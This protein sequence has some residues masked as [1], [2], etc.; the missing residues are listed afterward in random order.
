MNGLEDTFDKSF[1][2]FGWLISWELFVNFVVSA[3]DSGSIESIHQGHF[4]NYR[5]GKF[6]GSGKGFSRFSLN[7][8]AKAKLN[9]PISIGVIYGSCE[10]K[11]GFWIN[12]SRLLAESWC[13]VIP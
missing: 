11:S 8:V 10:E 2:G 6:L 1:L 9:W 7:H 12:E 5:T 4:K 3:I 13:L